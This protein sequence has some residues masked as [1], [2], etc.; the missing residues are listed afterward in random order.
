LVSHPGY[1]KRIGSLGSDRHKAAV[2]GLL[3]RDRSVRADLVRRNIK[4]LRRIDAEMKSIRRQMAELLETT[5][6]SLTNQC[7]VGPVI[8]ARLL[9]EVG[10]VRNVRSKAAF[11]RLSGT[12][13]V[14]ASSGLTVRHRLNRHGNRKLNYALHYIAVTRCRI[15]PETRVFMSRKIAEGK[16]RKEAMRSLKRHL[17]NAIYRIMVS[18][19]TA[20]GASDE[21]CALP[22]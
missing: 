9:G 15:D 3:R 5:D 17:S 21:L 10:D 18:D 19:L 12:A 22:G 16:T 6:T 11:A 7:G 4:E 1:D 8:A 13:P 20:Q 2:V 14:P